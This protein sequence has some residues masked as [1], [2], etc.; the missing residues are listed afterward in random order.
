ME[1]EKHYLKKYIYI[2]LLAFMVLWKFLNIPGAQKLYSGKK[3]SVDCS[4]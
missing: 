3:C 4:S 1:C 2:Y